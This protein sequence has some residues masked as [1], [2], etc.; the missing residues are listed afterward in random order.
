MLGSNVSKISA[1]SDLQF[2]NVIEQASSQQNTLGERNS[3][4]QKN[5]WDLA[6]EVWKGLFHMFDEG[7]LEFFVS[8]S[9]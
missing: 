9:I 7:D 4:W 1:D 8:W 2:S 6:W 5:P 3:L